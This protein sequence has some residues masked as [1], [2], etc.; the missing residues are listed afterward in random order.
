MSARGCRVTD[1]DGKTYVDFALGDTGSM[2]GHSP[3]ATVAA[4][5]RRCRDDG[6]LTT[7]LPTADAEWVASDMT[8]HEQT[9]LDVVDQ[10]ADPRK[11]RVDQNRLVDPK[12]RLDVDLVAV[13]TDESRLAL[14]AE[15]EPECTSED[16]LTC[17]GLTGN[18]RHSGR[19]LNFRR[20]EHDEVIDAKPLQ[21]GQW[22]NL[23]R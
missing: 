20:A 19:G 3:D 22:P 6:G 14:G 7:M 16:C 5:V 4:I 17:T 15:H 18:Y 10:L 1:A 23:S 21:H 8:R 11:G 9:I 2:T 13:W 12:I